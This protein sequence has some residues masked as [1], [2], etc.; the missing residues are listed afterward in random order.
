M[1]M[2]LG[3]A[4][5]TAVFPPGERGRALG[6]QATVTY[7]A[8]TVGPS[9]GGWI[10]G[11]LGWPW[12]FFV[13]LPVAALGSLAAL[14]ALAPD[15]QRRG[16]GFDLPG[17]VLLAAGLTAL[18]VALT[19]GEEGGWRS[20][21]REA[22]LAAGALLLALFLLH[23]G[24][25][26]T[27]MLPL[28]LFREPA[29]TGPVVAAFLQYAAVFMLLFLMPFYLQHLRGFP[30]QQAGALMTAQPALM[31]ALAAASGWL[32]DRIGTRLPAA[33]G[34]SCL[35]LGLW[36]TAHLDAAAPA[37][38]VPVRLATVGAG[39]G[40][41]TAPNNSAILA[42]APLHHRG[43][44]AGLMALARNLGMV[45][46]VALAG[47]L[48][49]FLQESHLARGAASADAFL[50]AFRST[51]LVAAGLAAAGAALSLLRPSPAREAQDHRV[52]G[53]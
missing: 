28:Q 53:A 12:V 33:A 13:N 18:L 35:S 49:G 2:A 47:A 34:M 51:L 31:V 5:L 3:P 1:L 10:A 20:P 25:A 19:R 52:G 23:E 15:G 50:R 4:L 11:H 37:W 42:A 40:L 8:L 41:F 6:L 21:A 39:S 27:P 29:F 22:L 32:S 45:T 9:L 7:V 43:V 24:R 46:G 36:L 26:P 48:F 30:P 44:A 17:A 14:R 38:A 16:Q